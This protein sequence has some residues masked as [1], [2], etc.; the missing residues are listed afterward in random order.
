MNIIAICALW[1]FS[2]IRRDIVADSPG[3]F[4]PSLLELAG[5][6]C[7]KHPY[8]CVFLT[9]RKVYLVGG[10]DEN[11]GVLALFCWPS[12]VSILSI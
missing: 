5:K 3:L 11:H 10:S 9:Y 7:C 1:Q 4:L 12:L 6:M 8:F 2:V